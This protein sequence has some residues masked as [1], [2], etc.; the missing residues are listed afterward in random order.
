MRLN[1][2]SGL[3]VEQVSSDLGIGKSTLMAWRCHHRGSGTTAAPP[4]DDPAKEIG[5][6]RCEK[7]VLRQ[8]RDLLKKS[9]PSSRRR[10]CDDVRVHRC[11]EGRYFRLTGLP[12]IGCIAK[13]LFRLERPPGEPEPHEDMV[14]LAYI[15]NA[16]ALSNGTYGSPR[17]TYD[18]KAGGFYCGTATGC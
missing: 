18:L 7:E 8:E 4:K 14:L 6:L 10:Q 3:T 2:E 15:R 1:H 13:W 5:R 16:F 9:R 12:D 11:G 17:M